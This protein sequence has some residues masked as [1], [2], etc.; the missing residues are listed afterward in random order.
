MARRDCCK[1]AKA[2]PVLVFACCIAVLSAI[3]PAAATTLVDFAGRTVTL[4]APAVRIVAL[5]PHIVENA[6]SAGAGDKL[7]GAVT[8]SDFPAAAR[9]I[10]RVGSYQA[11]SL[12]AIVASEPDLVLIWGSGNGLETVAALER[13]GIPVYV[14]EL[15]ALTDIPASIRAIGQLAGTS[16]VSEREAARLER[17]FTALRQRYGARRQMSV[18]YQIWNEPLQTINGEHLISSVIGLCGGHNAFADASSLAPRV[19][20][21]SV[22]VRDPEVILASGMG[23][24]RPDWLDDWRAYPGLRAVRSN[25]L[26]FIHPDLIQ[27]PTARILLGARALCEQLDAAR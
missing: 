10:P 21:E 18:F 15:R 12:E 14:S 2:L 17:E 25:A 19:S 24:A 3:R 23:E 5:A 22:L 8:Y 27:R 9:N 1:S 7:V 20:L 11:W 13:L 26:F 4:A 16:A 6:F